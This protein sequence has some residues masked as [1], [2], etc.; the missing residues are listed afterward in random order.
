MA[1]ALD[2]PRQ[3]PTDRA[4]TAGRWYSLWKARGDRRPL[5][6][7]PGVGPVLLAAWCG[8]LFF[9]GITQGDLWRTEGLRAIIAAEFLRSGN[10]VVPTLYGEP[11]FTKPPGTYA[12][13]ALVSAPFGGVTT[14]SARLPSA[15]AATLTVVAFAAGFRRFLGPTA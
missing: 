13:I 11:L 6:S 2:H 12:A 15:L 7:R 5:L 9:Y 14:W 4:R 10:W 1:T 3:L 8:L